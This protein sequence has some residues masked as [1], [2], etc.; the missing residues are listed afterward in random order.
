MRLNRAL[1]FLDLQ[2]E[3]WLFYGN[4]ARKR[5]RQSVTEQLEKF[6]RALEATGKQQA[7]HDI[8]DILIVEGEFN[9]SAFTHL[10]FVLHALKESMLISVAHFSMNTQ[11][12]RRSMRKGLF[13]VAKM[14]DPQPVNV[15]HSHWNSFAYHSSS[16][17]GG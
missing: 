17:S 10:R 2:E 16:Q 6:E 3:F 14:L 15:L 1:K 5:R 13:C 11:S 12:S 9:K 8:T 7:N 4:R